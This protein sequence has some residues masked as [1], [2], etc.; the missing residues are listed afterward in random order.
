MKP[1]KNVK[2]GVLAGALV[3]AIALGGY[4][5]YSYLYPNEEPN[6]EKSQSTSPVI[7]EKKKTTPVIPKKESKEKTV[8]NVS[9]TDT[10]PS[11][12]DSFRNESGNTS[13]QT[14]KNKAIALLNNQVAE[15]TTRNKATPQPMVEKP[16]NEQPSTD[17]ETKPKPTPSPTP[18]PQPEPDPTPTPPTPPV[19]EIDYSVLSALVGQAEAIDRSLYLTTGIHSFNLELVVAQR[20]LEEGASTQEAVNNQ[21][22][23]LQQAIDQLVL[24]GNKTALQSLYAHSNTIKRD[25]YTQDT[26]TLFEEAKKKAKETLDEVEVDQSTVDTAQQALQQSIDGLKEKEEP[27]LSLAYLERIVAEAKI[28]DSTLY[29]PSTVS[30]FQVKL[31]EVSAYIEA[32]TYTK[33]ENEQYATELQ[34]AMNQLVKKA[35]TTELLALKNK[36]EGIDRTLY[37]TESLA[38]LDGALSNAQLALLNEELN[39]D[40]LGVVIDELNQ[41]L[42]SLTEKEIEE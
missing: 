22:A 24:K 3:C 26:V 28:V 36:A 40:E 7:K 6:Q 2:K 25:I 10:L 20:I 27:Y 11:T 38:V 23:R 37:T 19:V 9:K 41:A 32:G 39:Q 33:V 29:T 35:D 13:T 8:E 5:G 34:E 18:K 21:V 31:A 17:K 4:T 15:E 42:N 16:A 30:A 12:I 14:E 1:T